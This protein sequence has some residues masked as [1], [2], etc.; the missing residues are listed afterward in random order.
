MIPT[1]KEINAKFLTAVNK[2]V[3]KKLLKYETPKPQLAVHQTF[4]TDNATTTITVINTVRGKIAAV[5]C[6]GELTA[7]E[8]LEMADM[9]K[10]LANSLG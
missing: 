4:Y 8:C 2:P 10:E 5:E 9:L 7:N 3:H 1:L 6:S